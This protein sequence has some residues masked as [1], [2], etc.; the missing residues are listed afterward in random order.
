[1][2]AKIRQ[3]VWEWRGV[4]ITTP[5]MAGLVILLRFSGILQSWEWAVYDQYMRLRPPEP[6][7]ER[8][9]IVGLNEADMKYIGGVMYPTKFML[10]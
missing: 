2:R 6:R 9:A 1:M 7:D 4:W 5:V 3:L 8:I 10:N